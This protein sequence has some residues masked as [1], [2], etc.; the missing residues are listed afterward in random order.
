MPSTQTRMPSSAVAVNVLVPPVKS[1][2]PDQRT[3]MP[4]VGALP[5]GPLDVMLGSIAAVGAHFEIKHVEVN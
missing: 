5:H 4:S 2:W 3:E 1:S